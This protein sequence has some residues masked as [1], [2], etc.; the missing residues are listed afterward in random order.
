VEKVRSEKASVASAARLEVARRANKRQAAPFSR[1]RRAFEA[2]RK[3]PG[4]KPGVD[5]GRHGHRQPPKTPDEDIVVG[6]PDAC[7][8]CG[9]TDL[10][11]ED[12][13]EQFQDELVAAVVRRRFLVARGR[14]PSC[15]GM[16][17][18]RHPDQTSDAVGAVGA[19]LGP[20]ALALAAWLR[21]RCGASA[22]KIA[23]LFGEFGLL[24]PP[25]RRTIRG[26]WGRW[27]WGTSREVIVV[28]RVTFRPCWR[29]F[30]S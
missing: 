12:F 3:R 29:V 6:L 7:P 20:K 19:R 5:H 28:E 24:R 11:V 16:V 14:C 1:D 26:W 10:G 8:S 22:A 21:Y 4:R 25:P 9:C 30:G 2:K 13:S 18:G 17:R 27:P 15:Q 23:R